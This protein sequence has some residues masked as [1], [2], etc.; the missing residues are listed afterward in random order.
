MHDLRHTAISRMIRQ[1]V[2]VVT[3]QRQAGHSKPSITL[4]IYSH[5][6]AEAERTAETREKLSAASRL[7]LV[8]RPLSDHG[9]VS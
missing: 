2:D 3:V 9:P 1:G 8:F 5:E 7:G 6:F 4:D